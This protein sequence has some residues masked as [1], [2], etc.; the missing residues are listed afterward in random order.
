MYEVEVIY[1]MLFTDTEIYFPSF[2]KY[3]Q[4]FCSLYIQIA[5]R[6]S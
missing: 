5:Y 6:K 2:R 1:D 3:F 4:Q